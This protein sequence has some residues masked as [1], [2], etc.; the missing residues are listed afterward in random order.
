[1]NKIQITAFDLAQRFIGIKEVNGPLSNP[2]ILA[3]LKLDNEWPED[4]STAWCS[5]YVSYIA[6]LLRLPR[7]KSLRARS[8]LAVGRPIELKDAEA[9]FDV[10]VLKQKSKDAGAD[11]I[12]APGHVGFF[13]GTETVNSYPRINVL[14]GNQSNSVSIVSYPT[15]L[16][17]GIRRLYE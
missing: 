17:L 3:M 13:A 16:L 12:E 15:S 5:S 11:I 9:G 14:G 10:V 6:W 4:D 7:S 1:M 8:W 2:A